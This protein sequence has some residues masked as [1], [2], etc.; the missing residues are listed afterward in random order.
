MWIPYIPLTILAVPYYTIRHY[1]IPSWPGW[2]WGGMIRNRLNKLWIEIMPG[3]QVDSMEV[4]GTIRPEATKAA[5][6]E[7]EQ[8]GDL[9]V[10]SLTLEPVEEEF[11]VGIAS[12][13]GVKAVPVVAF[14]LTPAGAAGQTD[15]P[16]K[17]GEKAILHIHG[18]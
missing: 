18:G 15:E 1:L 5:Y 2:T 4:D 17:E 12:C 3:F 16:A 14:W 10:V 6:A 8:K 11:R 9:N 13:P 7:A